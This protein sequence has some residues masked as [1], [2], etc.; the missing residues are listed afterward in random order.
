MALDGQNA[1]CVSVDEAANLLN[2]S[3]RTIRMFVNHGDLPTV[4][5]PAVRGPEQQNRRVLIAVD[6][7]REFVARHREV[8]K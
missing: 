4:K 6:D 1:L 7:L 8:N 5:L 2:V 3:A